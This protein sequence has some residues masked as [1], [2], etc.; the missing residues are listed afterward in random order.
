MAFSGG[1]AQIKVVDQASA[2]DVT[3]AR[4]DGGWDGVL[5]LSPTA[6]VNV[7]HSDFFGQIG[8]GLSYLAPI[9]N[10]GCQKKLNVSHVFF[11]E[12][13]GVG[14]LI[15]NCR[16]SDVSVGEAFVLGLVM[17]NLNLEGQGRGGVLIQNSGPFS[18]NNVKIRNATT[19]GI[20][21]FGSE[22]T[23]ENSV[24]EDTAAD[25]DGRFGDGVVIAPTGTAPT[26]KRSSLTM[27][28]VEIYR[29]A[30]AGHFNFGSASSIG[31]V[32][33]GGAP[34]PMAAMAL[35]GFAVSFKDLGNAVCS[36]TGNKDSYGRCSAMTAGVEASPP[37]S[38]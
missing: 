11:G 24:I 17:A 4:F 28:E 1:D 25:T 10:D 22:V 18:L 9:V 19:F 38:P 14:V 12:Q 36:T 13:R 6:S 3:H 21:T 33:I 31:N 37:A 5:N 30:R 7:V 34:M 2:L 16:P 29:S 27:H 26:G 20:A 32:K 15:K 8:N 35:S 23:L